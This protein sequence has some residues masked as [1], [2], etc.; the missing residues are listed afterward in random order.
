MEFDYHPPAFVVLN[1]SRAIEAEPDGEAYEGSLTTPPC[2]ESVHWN[3]LAAPVALSAAQVAAF[4]E[5][6]PEGTHRPVQEL[7]GRVVAAS[8]RF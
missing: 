5:L 8:S 1:N 6:F 2:S 3:V 4:R 7:N